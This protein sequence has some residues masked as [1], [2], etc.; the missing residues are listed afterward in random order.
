LGVALAGLGDLEEAR[1]HLAEALRLDPH[2]EQA[3]QNLAA[4]KP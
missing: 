4:L 3:R 1:E 2:H